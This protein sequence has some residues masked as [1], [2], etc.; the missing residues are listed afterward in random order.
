MNDEFGA[1]LAALRPA[2]IKFARMQLRD[3]SLSEDLVQEALSVAVR[4]RAQYREDAALGTWLTG[5]LKNKIIDY[6]RSHREMVS[7]DDSEQ[8]A[9]IDSKYLACFDETDHWRPDSSPASWQEGSAETHLERQQF[10]QTLQKCLENLPAN[11]ARIFYLREI[12]G[13]EVDEICRDFNITPNN[14]YAILH[15]ARNGLRNCL[16]ANWFGSAS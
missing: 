11:T 10:F 8:A 2:L 9:R 4:N 7:L 5:I 15:R 3:D 13:M 14:C 1:K 6:Y 12:M 16:Q